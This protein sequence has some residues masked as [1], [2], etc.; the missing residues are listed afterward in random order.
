MTEKAALL[1][2]LY[3]TQGETKAKLGRRVHFTLFRL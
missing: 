1:P 2:N 3:D